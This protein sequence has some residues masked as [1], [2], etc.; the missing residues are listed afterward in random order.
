M[1]VN[2]SLYDYSHI[3]NLQI[4]CIFVYIKRTIP[5]SFSKIDPYNSHLKLILLPIL[6]R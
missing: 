1:F 5:T 6:E 4:I 2:L 3:T